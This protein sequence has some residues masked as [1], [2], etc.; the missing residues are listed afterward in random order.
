[1]RRRYCIQTRLMAWFLPVP[2][3]VSIEATEDY[4]WTLIPA[5][6]VSEKSNDIVAM[7]E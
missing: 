7:Y 1:M 5:I 4:T 3:H 2:K 6:M